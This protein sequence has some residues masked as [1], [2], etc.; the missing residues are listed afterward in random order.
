[1]AICNNCGKTLIIRNGKCVYCGAAPDG[2]SSDYSGQSIGDLQGKK[3]QKNGKDYKPKLIYQLFLFFLL[4]AV[5]IPISL[6]EYDTNNGLWWRI[7]TIYCVNG[8][9]ILWSILTMVYAVRGRFS[10]RE[11]TWRIYYEWIHFPVEILFVLVGFFV[12]Y[13]YNE[14][15]IL[16]LNLLTGTWPIVGAH[17]IEK[18]AGYNQWE[19]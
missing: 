16:S 5:I 7:A 13:N 11:N 6:A 15:W 17:C 19:F 2:G 12:L 18:T 4:L 3:Q 14:T 1:M 8:A 10:C 9:I